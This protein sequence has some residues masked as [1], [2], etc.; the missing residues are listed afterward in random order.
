M[1]RG[2]G[3]GAWDQR[4]SGRDL[5]RDLN[6]DLSRNLSRNLNRDLERRRGDYFTAPAA[7]PLMI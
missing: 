7:I 1:P 4:A 2:A 3:P 6:R 5:S